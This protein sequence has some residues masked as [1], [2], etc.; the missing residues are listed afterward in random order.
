MCSGIR[1]ADFE[2]RGITPRRYLGIG[3][4]VQRRVGI[5]GLL[6]VVA[7]V[8]VCRGRCGR[9]RSPYCCRPAAAAAVL[10]LLL[11]LWLRSAPLLL[12]LLLLLLHTIVVARAE[13][14]RHAA[15]ASLL[16]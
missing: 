13:V 8:T 5:T 15:C 2:C 12:L 7:E 1:S 9:R 11:V 14:L 10:P 6:A 16:R 3:R 4:A